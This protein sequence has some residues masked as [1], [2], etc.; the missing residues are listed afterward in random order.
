M[1]NTNK[2]LE[3][4]SSE[5]KVNYPESSMGLGFFRQILAGFC[6]TPDMNDK[7]FSA[8]VTSG[9]DN[10]PVWVQ[11][12]MKNVAFV[13]ADEPTAQQRK[14]NDIALEETLFGLYEGIPQTERGV[15]YDAVLP[16]KITIFKK[17]I[18][19]AYSNIDDIRECVFNTIWH[20]VAHHFG[21][22]EEEVRIEERKR[23]KEL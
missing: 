23:G 2:T 3:D 9:I 15:A 21:M 18:L 19:A 11:Q 7:D 16:D 14:D 12:K 13:I 17:P 10:L 5:F 4:H 6:Y 22:D 8:L 1:H 20:E